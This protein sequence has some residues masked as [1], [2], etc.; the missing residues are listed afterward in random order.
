MT[1][2]SGATRPGPT[3]LAMAMKSR[4]GGGQQPT[5]IL[6]QKREGKNSK[7][8]KRG[9]R[10]PASPLRV[11]HTAT[12]SHREVPAQTARPPPRFVPSC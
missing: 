7:E 1:M 2:P 11:L 6:L 8:G 3:G 9:W 5:A 4:D 10:E 12:A